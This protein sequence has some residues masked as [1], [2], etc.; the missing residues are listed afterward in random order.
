MR[1]F[2]IQLKYLRLI[3]YLL[4]SKHH[5]E[6]AGKINPQSFSILFGIN[7]FYALH[8]L[9]ILQTTLMKGFSMKININELN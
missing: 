8:A 4:S 9:Q 7:I 5:Y 2:A 1:S 6:V 3:I